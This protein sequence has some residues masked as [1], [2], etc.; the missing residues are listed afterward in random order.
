[1]SD[2]FDRAVSSLRASAAAQRD[3][4]AMRGR[5]MASLHQRDRR[6]MTAAA[7]LIPLAAV[8]VGSTA[9]GAGSGRMRGAWHAVLGWALPARSEPRRIPANSSNPLA[10]PPAPTA[11]APANDVAA[12]PLDTTVEKPALAARPRPPAA[13]IDT[14]AEQR[15]AR[16][17]DL[18][19]AAHQAHFVDLDPA[20]AL[21]RWDAYLAAFPRGSLA[22]EARYNRALC[23]VRLGR[24]EEARAALLPFARGEF[25]AYRQKES[26]ALLAA[27]PGASP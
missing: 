14:P 26:E 4:D 13:A 9:W 1:M 22:L 3:P 11:L 15:A 10:V 27:L 19:R 23:L 12:A 24:N 16:A 5:I 8:L 21:Q 20:R 25:G 7:F 17:Q 2:L 18:Y 6:R